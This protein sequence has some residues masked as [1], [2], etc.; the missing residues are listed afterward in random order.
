[1]AQALESG[2]SLQELEER[3]CAAA[4]RRSGGNVAQAARAL[5]WTRAQ[6]DYRLTKTKRGA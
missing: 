5:G 2:V 4:R 3:M 1:M 6:L